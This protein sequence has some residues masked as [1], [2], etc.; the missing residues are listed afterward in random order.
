M[1]ARLERLAAAA[2]GL[3][4]AV[5]GTATPPSAAEYVELVRD[6]SYRVTD[7][8]IEALREHGLSD[9]AIFELT[10]ATAFGVADERLAAGLALLDLE[11]RS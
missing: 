7:R 8:H 10:V 3:R 1:T 9:D 5:S 4:R 6:G 11:T 2:D